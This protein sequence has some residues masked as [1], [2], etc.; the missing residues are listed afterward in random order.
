MRPQEGEGHA[1]APGEVGRYDM[2]G[3]GAAELVNRLL[4]IGAGH[5]REPG[6]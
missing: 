3:A 4:I 2:I 1:D 6:V 5:R